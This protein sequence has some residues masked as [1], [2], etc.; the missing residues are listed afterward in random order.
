MDIHNAKLCSFKTINTLIDD[1]Q[2][3]FLIQKL[4]DKTELTRKAM[5]SE[6]ELEPNLVLN[7]LTLTAQS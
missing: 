4:L 7:N 5:L 6:T 3:V 1:K 2:F